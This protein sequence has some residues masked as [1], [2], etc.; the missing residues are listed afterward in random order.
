MSQV[1]PSERNTDDPQ[2]QPEV[3]PAGSTP[4][5][6]PYPLRILSSQKPLFLV[7]LGMV[8]GLL[9]GIILSANLL[10]QPTPTEKLQIQP[11]P[12]QATQSLASGSIGQATTIGH[13][14]VT[15]NRATTSRGDHVFAPHAGEIFLIVDVTVQNDSSDPQ[16]ISSGLMFILKDSTGQA[17]N[18][19]ITDIGRPLD[20][21]V[22]VGDKLRGQIVYE[23][24]AGE[25]VFTFQFQDS[26]YYA[27]VGIW[28]LR[29]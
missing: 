8:I 20:G 7:S 13:W 1:Q 24:P 23:V 29:V 19:T 25:H 4:R 14:Q 28:D 22:Q 12:A 18:E 21:T 16:L 2:L 9:L 5:Q 10:R 3:Q 26:T 15:V 6:L 27:N 17:Y 11:P